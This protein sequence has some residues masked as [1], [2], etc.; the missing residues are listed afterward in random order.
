MTEEITPEYLA[1]LKN[2][3]MTAKQKL[4]DKFLFEFL[5]NLENDQTF[6]KK[7]SADLSLQERLLHATKKLNDCSVVLAHKYKPILKDFLALKEQEELVLQYSVIKAQQRDDADL[8]NKYHA[9]FNAFLNATEDVSIKAIDNDLIKNID[10]KDA[11]ILTFYSF[12]TAQR[13]ESDNL[14]QLAICGFT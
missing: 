11:F 9:C 7:N 3:L 10:I 5:C 1:V 14:A 13:Q 2:Q 12:A 4:E 8:A 6:E